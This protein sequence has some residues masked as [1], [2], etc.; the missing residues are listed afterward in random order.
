MIS[1]LGRCRKMS[2]DE[3]KT[4]FLQELAKHSDGMRYRLRVPFRA[5]RFTK[6]EAPNS[7]PRFFFDPEEVGVIVHLLRARLPH[8]CNEL[9]DR[10]ER[11][12]DH[13]ID[14]LGYRDLRFERRIEWSLDAVHRVIAPRKPWFKVSYL[15]F[16]EV[17][18][19]KITWELNRHQHLVILAKAYRLTGNSEFVREL[20]GQ[21]RNWHVENP[22]PIGINWASS[23]EV[24][25]RSLSWLWVKYLL[26]D[27]QEIAPEFWQQ[28]NASL[29][30]HA[31]HIYR[32]LS[33]YFSPNTHLLGEAMALFF[34]GTLL[35][36]YKQAEMWKT[37]G[38]RI[39]CQELRR[40]IR[41]DG[42]HFEQS[43]YYHVYSLDFFLHARILAERNRVEIPPDF[44]AVLLKMLELLLA[45][46]GAGVPPRFGDD[47]GGRVFDGQRNR[48]EHLLDPLATGAVLFRR[49]EFKHVSGGLREETI[50]LF[51]SAGVTAFDQIPAR[52]LSRKS[53]AFPDTG[54]YVLKNGE[55]AQQQITIDAGPLG[56]AS[57]GHGHADLLSLTFAVEGRELLT[58]PGTGEYVGPGPEREL[59]R[60]TAAHNTLEVDGAS[61]ALPTGPFS[62]DAIPRVCVATWATGREVD[63]FAGQH[64]AYH[65]LAQAVT[66]RREVFRTGKFWLVRD[67]AEGS[68][69]HDLRLNWHF[70]PDLHPRKHRAGCTLFEDEHGILA[71]VSTADHGWNQRLVEHRFSAAYGNVQPSTTLRLETRSGLPVEFVSLWAYSNQLPLKIGK[72]ELLTAASDHRLTV[73]RYSCARECHWFCFSN[74]G[75]PWE[76][77]AWKSDVRFAYFSCGSDEASCR[78]VLV[79]G[80]VFCHNGEPVIEAQDHSRWFEYSGSKGADKNVNSVALDRCFAELQ[81]S[82]ET[83]LTTKVGKDRA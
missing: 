25:F 65:R 20:L 35:P 76:F 61:Q 6:V 83:E 60:S 41:P 1:R 24:A 74:T 12:L 8:V 28:M 68:G 21:W 44:D 70:H 67:R 9:L 2:A 42:G 40:Q 53:E 38:W 45:L 36:E 26:W 37:E 11:L 77:G 27:C 49:P 39:V 56:T 46:A 55:G 22:Y 71:F 30:L 75:D 63:Y 73:Y 81:A 66:H 16:H 10:A 47:D 5:G 50:W 57:G 31:R 29:A 13:R 14:L 54:I 48:A 18:D 7:H 64:T 80:H 33:T 72:L 3:V 32:F 58:D 62:W 34:I 79:E 17:G 15:D 52:P 69:T 23:L 59:F 19:S 43:I 82:I 51:A 4:R 78:L